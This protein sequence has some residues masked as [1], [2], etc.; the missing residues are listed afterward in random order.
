M[1]ARR[2]AISARALIGSLPSGSGRQ[3]TSA[4]WS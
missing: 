4:R 2:I 3:P 1:A